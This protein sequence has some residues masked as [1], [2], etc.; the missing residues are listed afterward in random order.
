MCR[1]SLYQYM[2]MCFWDSILL[3]PIAKTPTRALK[4]EKLMINI[5]WF[6]CLLHIVVPTLQSAVLQHTATH[7]SAL[8]HTAAHYNTQTDT[9][10]SY[11]VAT[12]SRID[13]IVGIFC[14]ISSHLQG[15]CA[16]KTYNFIDPTNCSHPIGY[17]GE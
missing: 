2:C 11:G 4:T 1:I 16:K 15:L 7:S 14:R 5:G 12:V 6:C 3:Y 17:D 10:T 8:Q 9:Y 13:K